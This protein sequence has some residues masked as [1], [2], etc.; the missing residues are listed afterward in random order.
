M[1]NAISGICQIG[2]QHIQEQNEESSLTAATQAS[3]VVP[4]LFP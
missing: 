4:S 2:S 1:R 3:K